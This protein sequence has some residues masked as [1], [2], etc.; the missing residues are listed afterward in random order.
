MDLD[1]LTQYEIEDIIKSIRKLQE[2][3]RYLEEAHNTHIKTVINRVHLKHGIDDGI[4]LYS[5]K[6]TLLEELASKPRLQ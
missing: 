3:I 5:L 6:K 2:N 1:K 4:D